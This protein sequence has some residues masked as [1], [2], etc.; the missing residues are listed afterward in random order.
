MY[1][2]IQSGDNDACVSTFGGND[3]KRADG[4]LSICLLRS[5]EGTVYA[6]I[7]VPFSTRLR[8]TRRVGDQGGLTHQQ[9]T[10]DT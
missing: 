9:T 6:Q 10:T 5:A 7:S 8:Q 4:C 1:F 3:P 2:A